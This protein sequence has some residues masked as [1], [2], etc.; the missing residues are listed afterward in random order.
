MISAISHL[1]KVPRSHSPDLPPPPVVEPP[2]NVVSSDEDDYV[3]P[4]NQNYHNPPENDYI[5]LGLTEL[6]HLRRLNVT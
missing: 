4:P 5:D 1:R 2:P 3:A 6:T